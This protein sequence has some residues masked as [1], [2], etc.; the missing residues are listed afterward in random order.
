MKFIKTIKKTMLVISATYIT[1][2]VLMIINRQESNAQAFLI[3]TYGLSIAGLLSMIR[4]F[5]IN[6]K[7]RVKRNDFVI[8]ALLISIAAVIYLTRDN[9]SFLTG[10][11]L[12]IAMII[13]GFHKIQDMFDVGAAGRSNVGIYLF[14]FIVCV[15]LGA[16]ILF[17]VITNENI[18]Y[19]VIGIGMCICGISDIV[20]NFYVAFSV[21]EYEKENKEPVFNIPTVDEEPI[22]E[23]EKEENNEL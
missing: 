18:L 14:G 5:L 16:L 7:E 9:V 23:E 10:K 19:V 2:G 6:V 11:I 1:I 3:L 21:S 20:S 15:G 22:K 8:G 4:Y 12:A 17:E 13:S